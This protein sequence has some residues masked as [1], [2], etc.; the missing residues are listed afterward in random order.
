MVGGYVIDLTLTPAS[1]SFAR[2]TPN[3]L[4]AVSS[5]VPALRG[6]A[7]LLSAIVPFEVIP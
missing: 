5:E 3:G 7:R 4:H 2:S 6:D 1:C